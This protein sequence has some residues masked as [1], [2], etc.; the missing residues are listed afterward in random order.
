MARVVV[1]I[2]SETGAVVDVAGN[3]RETGRYAKFVKRML[4]MDKNPSLNYGF[5]GGDTLTI[6]QNGGEGAAVNIKAK[7]L[8]VSG[9]VKSG[10]QTLGQIALEQV[11]TVLGRIDG[12]EGEVDVATLTDD[13]GNQYL[14][15]SLSASVL[16]QL[17]AIERDMDEQA[18]GVSKFVTKEAL[19][20]AIDGIT[21]EEE[22]GV[23]E[24][25]TKFATLLANIAALVAE[26]SGLDSGSGEE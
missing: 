17:A 14:Q 23:E 19:A 25:K 18:E 26:Q 1:V 22:D 7:V 6:S 10:G 12:T 24:V 2:D 21:I 13:S 5:N 15:I 4:S 3:K 20:A 16:N 9:Q 8:N 11:Q